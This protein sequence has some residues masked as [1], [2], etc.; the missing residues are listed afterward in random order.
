MSFESVTHLKRSLL[1]APF[2]W[3]GRNRVSGDVFDDIASL[4]SGGTTDPLHIAHQLAQALACVFGGAGVAV[5]LT[6]FREPLAAVSSANAFAGSECCVNR[7]IKLLEPSRITKQ[8]LAGAQDSCSCWTRVALVAALRRGSTLFGVVLVS[9]S[10]SSLGVVKSSDTDLLER[11]LGRFAPVLHVSLL[12]QR[13]DE[14]THD[15]QIGRVALGFAHDVGKQLAWLNTLARRLSRELGDS[16]QIA[17]DIARVEELG[18]SIFARL[19][20]L[21][22]RAKAP[23]LI[24]SRMAQVEDLARSAVWNVERIRGPQRIVL[25]TDCSLLGVEVATAFEGVL[26]NLLDNAVQASPDRSVVRLSLSLNGSALVARVEDHGIGMTPEV[27]RRAFALGYSG[28]V[29]SEGAGVGLYASN[30]V[31]EALGGSID[32][33]S[34]PGKGTIATVQLPLGGPS[35]RLRTLGAIPDSDD[36]G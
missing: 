19:R 2:R 25:T 29:P 17:R 36:A 24:A 33:E 8:I 11:L 5:H 3:L 30:G 1:A 6:A 28:R 31:V 15:A 32:V 34:E 13:L 20:D 21:V 35:C 9:F 12:T 23:G 4:E 27:R 14:A 7:V 10:S 16:S 26:E 18:S 22:A